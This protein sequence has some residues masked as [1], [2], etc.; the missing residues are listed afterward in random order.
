MHSSNVTEAP[1][2]DM[3]CDDDG[4]DDWGAVL[5]HFTFNAEAN[6]GEAPKALPPVA[7]VKRAAEKPPKTKKEAPEK[8][9]KAE[10]PQKEKEKTVAAKIFLSTQQR[11]ILAAEQVLTEARGVLDVAREEEGINTLNETK[12]T[13]MISKVTKKTA[14]DSS[15]ILQAANMVTTG[16]G[17]NRILVNAGALC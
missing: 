12:L 7:G 11:N 9:E 16:E 1:V 17:R 3:N 5:P 15:V 2:L 6:G 14:S 8:K 4:D 10:T 13:A